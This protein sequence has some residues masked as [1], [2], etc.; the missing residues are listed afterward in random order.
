MKLVANN[1]AILDLKPKLT[2][3][4]NH[5]KAMS[6]APLRYWDSYKKGQAISDGK[7]WYLN[8]MKGAKDAK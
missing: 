3:H 8:K 7:G 6:E 2:L 5:G 1:P 4:P